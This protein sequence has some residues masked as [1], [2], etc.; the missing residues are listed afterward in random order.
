[1]KKVIRFNGIELITKSV[2]K[3]VLGFVNLNAV[4]HYIR[5]GRLEEYQIIGLNRKL[6]SLEQVKSLKTGK[7]QVNE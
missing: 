2:A 1:M 3:R 7:R 5:K 6:V 4:D